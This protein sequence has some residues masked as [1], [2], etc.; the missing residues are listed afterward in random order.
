MGS[1]P[2]KDL[3]GGLF[4]HGGLREGKAASQ[5]VSGGLFQHR[6]PTPTRSPPSARSL[7]AHLA[8]HSRRASPFRL[9]LPRKKGTVLQ[10]KRGVLGT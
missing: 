5:D 6:P 2:G 7:R 9:A 4:Q 8:A 1:G 10:A 3:S